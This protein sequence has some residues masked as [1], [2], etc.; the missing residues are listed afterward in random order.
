MLRIPKYLQVV[1]IKDT[2]GEVHLFG[3]YREINTAIDSAC[4]VLK[5]FAEDEELEELVEDLQSYGEASSERLDVHIY[6]MAGGLEEAST[7]DYLS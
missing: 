3:P 2:N 1:V 6:A 4:K 7:T 5:Q